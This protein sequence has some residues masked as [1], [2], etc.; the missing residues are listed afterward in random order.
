MPRDIVLNMQLKLN[1]RQENYSVDTTKGIDLSTP[2]KSVGGVSAFYLP[3]PV[4]T[5]FRAGG[6]VG[7]KSEGGPCNCEEISIS[8]HGNGTHTECVGHISLEKI[9]INDTLKDFHCIAGLITIQPELLPNGDQMVTL[10]AILPALATLN[11]CEACIIRTRP[12]DSSKLSRNYSGQNPCYLEPA[13][14]KHLA[15]IS[16]KHLIIDLPSIDREED[17]GLLSAHHAYWQYPENTRMNATITELAYIP[18]H[19]ADGFYLLNLMIASFESD[20]SPSKPI[21]FALEAC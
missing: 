19:V 11:D 1:F 17:G 5:P 15:E 7:S 20:A 16:I 4:Y 10:N 18:D 6:F 12:N 8:P 13:L 3:P 9:T 21:I 14:C 2:L